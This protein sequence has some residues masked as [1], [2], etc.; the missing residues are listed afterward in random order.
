MRTIIG[1][2]PGYHGALAAIS[3][4]GLEL[5]AMPTIAVGTKRQLDEDVLVS[6]FRRQSLKPVHVLIEAVHAMP[7]QGVV[8]M[9]SF[10]TS[11]GLLR[12]ICAGLG[13]SYEL[14]RPQEWQAV[15]LAGHPRSTAK[16]KGA[17]YL[18]ASRLWP[19]ANWRAT[20]KCR[21]PHDGMVDAAL[22]AEY[23]R[24]RAG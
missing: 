21:V 10:G 17:E 19:N 6:W 24:R 1:C 5:H 8:S 4:D 18:V 14:V 23:G 7:K 3:D 22:I 13:L 15:M 9:F 20:D 12:G 2:D 11:W 16:S